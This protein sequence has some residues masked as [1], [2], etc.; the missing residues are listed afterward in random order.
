MSSARK[1]TA[2]ERR[3]YLRLLA[4]TRPCWG[5]I[6]LAVVFG[7]LFGG[8]ILGMLAS[9]KGALAYVFGS[10]DNQIDSAATANQV[11]EDRLV[12]LVA[13]ELAVSNGRADGLVAGRGVDQGQ[14]GAARAEVT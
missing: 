3:T 11:G 2:Q 13:A 1:L 8:S 7:I 4:R 5:R 12:D 10:A 6:L 9:A 14:V